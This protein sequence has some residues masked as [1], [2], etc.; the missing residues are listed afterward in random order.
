MLN[1]CIRQR[2]ARMTPVAEAG[3][4]VTVPMEED[5]FFDAEE[6]VDSAVFHSAWNQPQGRKEATKLKLLKT[7]ETLYV[8]H[9]Q[10]TSFH[11]ISFNSLWINYF[12]QINLIIPL[13]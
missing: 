3:E 6:E 1:C 8:P 10:V 4:S 13:Q 12:F 9:T 5:E 2:N 11:S 7:G